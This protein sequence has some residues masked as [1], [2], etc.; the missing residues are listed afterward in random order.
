MSEHMLTFRKSIVAGVLSAGICACS[1]S[2][3]TTATP[4]MVQV[5]NC[6]P[7]QTV[8]RGDFHG[9]NPDLKALKPIRMISTRNGVV[10]G[11]VVVTRDQGPLVELKATVGDLV[12]GKGKIAASNVQIRFADRACGGKSWMPI[13]RFDCLLEKLP[14][15]VAPEKPVNTRAFK[16][17]FTPKSTQPVATV[18]VWVTVRVPEDAVSGDY[19]GTLTIMANEAMEAPVSIPVQL[20]VHGFRMPDPREFR[21]R[22]I[23]WMNPEALAKHY[24]VDFWS[25]RHFELMGQS[26]ER[27][28]ELG[29][30][31]IAIDVARDYP[32]RQNRDTMVKWVKQQDGTYK[33][34]FTVFDRYCDLAAEKI[35]KPFPLRL[36]L[37]RGPRNGGGGE[38]D[39]YPNATVLVLD[40]KTKEVTKLAAPNKLGSEEMKAFWKPFMDQLRVRLDKR[41][42]FDV[43]GINWMCYCGGMTKPLASMVRSIWPDGKWTDVTHSRVRRYKTMEKGVFAPVFVQSTVWN[44]GSLDRYMKWKSGPYPREYAGKLEPGTAWCTHA[45]NQYREDYWPSLWTHR[46]RHELAILKGNDGLECVGADHFPSKDSRGRYSRNWGAYAQGPNNGAAALLAPGN[47]GPLGTQRFEAMREGIQVCEAMIF[48]QKALEEKEIDGDL[49]VRANKVLDDHAKGVVG[50]WSIKLEQ[51]G[52]RTRKRAVWSLDKYLEG[53]A[54]RESALFEMAAEVQRAM[55][56]T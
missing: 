28:L 5:W 37:W 3:A 45:R 43:T 52:K 15:K 16:R 27:M 40:P 41:G 2:G 35:G 20:K 55:Q 29:S 30:R 6:T 42:W 50:S 8:A 53:F 19:T 54:E 48:I 12:G 22:T 44:G 13:H 25:D 51:R 21:V 31:H 9:V 38:T 10:S 23:G 1:A 33:Y 39:D 14:A 24:K 7:W 4:G 56:G 36:N 32:A 17:R 34:D 49:A 26:M 18:P 46:T 11:F 47:D